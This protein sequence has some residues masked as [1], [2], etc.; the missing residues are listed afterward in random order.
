MKRE[1]PPAELI[2]WVS[3]VARRCGLHEAMLTL[4]GAMAAAR[5]LAWGGRTIGSKAVDLLPH[6]AKQGV[7][8]AAD[9]PVD[10]IGEVYET[11]LAAK[12]RRARGVHFTPPE[13]AKEVV[14][15]TLGGLQAKSGDS[16]VVLRII[17][18]AMGCGAFVLAA[19]RFLRAQGGNSPS[20]C[21]LHGFDTDPLAVELA[22]HALALEAGTTPGDF[23]NLRVGDALLEAQGR[24]DAVIGNPPFG[25]AIEQR[26]AR[27]PAYD[28]QMRALY[29]D[30]AQGAFDTCLLFFALA[31]RLL[32]PHGRYG[33]IGPTALLSDDKPWQVFM[34]EHWRPRA[35]L[36]Y[37]VNR[38]G[39]AR[40][41]TTAFVGAAGPCEQVEVCDHDVDA[42]TNRVTW[43]KGTWFETVSQGPRVEMGATLG[44]RVQV[45][46]GCA[47]GAAYE[48][49][50]LVADAAAS[51][52][53][54][55]TTGAI[56]RYACKWGEMPIRYLGRD[57]QQPR[58][59]E[60]DV[61]RAVAAA[62]ERQRR[63]KI[64]VGGLTSVIE[65]WFDEDGDSAGVVSTW[66]LR[67][68]DQDLWRLLPLL[69]SATLSRIYMS[70]HGAKSMSGRQTTIYKQALQNLPMP[71]IGVW[72]T[73]ASR[74]AQRLQVLRRGPEFDALDEELHMVIAQAYGRTIAEAREDY[75]WW[76]DRACGGK[77]RL[78]ADSNKP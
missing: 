12:T 68:K 11:M 7:P 29:P 63:P 13:I 18:P 14:E 59:P 65:A 36:L 54:L 50:P 25:N 57:H 41:R 56:D 5:G 51:G 48:L 32:E 2:E 70:R 1:G 71:D 55:I 37:P 21:E 43:R 49:A 72:Q 26:T 19:M 46:A 27:D 47:T 66:V 77:S 40:I 3:A 9:S 23:S 78:C 35:L 75:H 62:R 8:V 31:M 69:N 20:I 6:P 74:I 16:R 52:L 44:D 28:A 4:V 64:L 39:A 33:L 67:P 34:H 76:R 17:D 42:Q 38:F 30:F 45:F 60:G 53:K 73:G 61:P 58:W 10:W 15:A 22:R 24:F